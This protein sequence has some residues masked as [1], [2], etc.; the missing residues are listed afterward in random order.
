[1]R[2]TGNEFRSTNTIS[3]LRTYLEQEDNLRG[4]NFEQRDHRE[5]AE[6]RDINISSAV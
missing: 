4:P 1:M 3:E 6:T 2:C 5:D